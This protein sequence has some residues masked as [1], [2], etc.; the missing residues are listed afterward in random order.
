MKLRD[1]IPNLDKP[2]VSGSLDTE[3]TGLAYDSRK[4][5]PGIAFVALRGTHADG[6]ASFRK[7][8]SLARP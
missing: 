5:G 6:H 3:I 4:A 2:A 1:L 8:S 7:P